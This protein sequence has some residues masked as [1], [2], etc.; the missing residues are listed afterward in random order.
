MSLIFITRARPR[1]YKDGRTWRQRLVRQE[2]NWTPLLS[3]LT[4]AYLYWK[5]PDLA[6]TSHTTTS[7]IQQDSNLA[8]SYD[9]FIHTIDLYTLSVSVNIPRTASMTAPEALM[10]QGY[11]ATSPILPSLAI[12]IRTLELFRRLRA[13][14]AS[15]SVEAFAKVLSDLYGVSNT[16]SIST[17]AFTK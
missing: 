11:M 9:F 6:P 2:L 14:K 13:R 17:S 7:D 3:P 16:L 10:Y 8:V 12:S 5:H 1:Q 15:L 4:D